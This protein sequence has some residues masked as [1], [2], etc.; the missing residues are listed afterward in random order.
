MHHPPSDPNAP[1]W[2]LDE[3][4]TNVVVV[5]VRTPD[6]FAAG[7]LPGARN[8]P[9]DELGVHL[10]ALPAGPVLTVCSKGGGRSQSA[11][12]VLREHGYDA[13]HLEGGFLG[14]AKR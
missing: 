1:S 13:R 4:P 3:A 10:E 7:S 11:A 2:T 9:L 5:D 14:F 8:L 6:E 12:R